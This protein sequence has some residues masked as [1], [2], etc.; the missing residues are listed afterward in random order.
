MDSQS[1]TGDVESEADGSGHESDDSFVELFPT[2][3]DSS[4][5]ESPDIRGKWQF[6]VDQFLQQK[7]S[8]PNFAYHLIHYLFFH[9][10]SHESGGI[11]PVLTEEYTTVTTSGI[12]SLFKTFVNQF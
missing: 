6:Y 1:E 11:N 10:K 5:I 3:I 4:E 9:N 7:N 8:N 2:R 12:E